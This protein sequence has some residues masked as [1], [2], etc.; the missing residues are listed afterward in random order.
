[1]RRA[2]IDAD[3]IGMEEASGVLTRG[4]Q[5]KCVIPQEWGPVRYWW[6]LLC[7]WDMRHLKFASGDCSSSRKKGRNHFAICAA[8]GNLGSAD[9]LKTKA[10][11]IFTLVWREKRDSR[12][13]LSE[14]RNDDED[15]ISCGHWSFNCATLAYTL[16][17]CLEEVKPSQGVLWD[18]F[19]DA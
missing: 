10:Y 11:Y 18:V 6:N 3:L 15:G 19:G 17:N 8:P 1:M 12:W 13:T 2:G 7:Q 5:C 14:E 4:S 16:V 9:T